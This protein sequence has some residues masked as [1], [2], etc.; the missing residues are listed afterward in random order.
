MDNDRPV[1]QTANGPLRERYTQ[2]EFRLLRRALNSIVKPSRRVGLG[3]PLL[4]AKRK[5]GTGEDGTAAAIS[6]RLL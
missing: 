3:P 5:R 6:D 1:R 4:P 2:N